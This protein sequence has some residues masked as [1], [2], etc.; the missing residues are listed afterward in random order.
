EGA[1][2]EVAGCAFVVELAALRGRERLAAY[3][4]HSLV[5]YDA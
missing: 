5:V 2:A 1:S 4:V 3:H